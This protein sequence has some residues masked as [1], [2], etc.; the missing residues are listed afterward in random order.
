[1]Y[2]PKFSLNK[3]LLSNLLEIERLY[4][5]LESEPIPKALLL[6]LEQRNLVQSSF[7]STKIE[8]NPMTKAQ[9]TNLI[10]D[11]RVPANRDEKEVRNYFDIL[12]DLATYAKYP[13][14]I[15]LALRLHKRL[16]TGVDDELAGKLR[17][18]KVVVGSYAKDPQNR[19]S[20][21]IK[22]NP[23]FHT[24]EKITDALRDL[25]QW[26][27]ES[28][29]QALIKAGV[30]HHHFQFLHPFVDGNGRV[31][32]LQTA[33]ILLQEGYKINRFFVL[34]DYYDIDRADYSDKLHSA[35]HGDLSEWLEYFTDGVKY[36]LQSALSKIADGLKT[37]NVELRPTNR[38]K[39]VLGYFAEN[40]EVTALDVA[41]SFGVSRQQ[42]HKL[43]ASLV[44]KGFLNRVGETKGTYYEMV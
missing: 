3:R 11:D 41:E 10:L 15:D 20:L 42:A 37:L 22:H 30:F 33:V 6:N 21:V 7:S 9:V 40:R 25:S 8:G 34:D 27:L 44:E 4:G 23:P 16:L 5:K 14:D 31:G 36:S 43:L 18:E 29:D 28:E 24:V 38:E 13:V 32:R 17:N 26:L 39:D 35:D 12:T 1:M 2:K 19:T